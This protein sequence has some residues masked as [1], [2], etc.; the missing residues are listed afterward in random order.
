MSYFYHHKSG[1][2]KRKERIDR[3]QRNL[4][5]ERGQATLPDFN[6]RLKEN[7][8]VSANQSHDSTERRDSQSFPRTSSSTT[9]EPDCNQ[10]ETIVTF[11][12]SDLVQL[13]QENLSVETDV[14]FVATIQK[15]TSTER[16]SEEQPTFQM[17][18]TR[19]LHNYDIGTIETDFLLPQLVDEVIRRGHE[20]MPSAFPRDRLNERFPVSLLFKNLPNGEKVERDW[21]VWSRSKSALFCLPCRLFSTNTVNRSYLCSPGGYSKNLAWKKLYERL[22]PHENNKDHIQCYV[23]WRGLEM[24]IRNESSIDKLLCKQIKVEVKKWQEILTRILDTILFLGERGLAL[25]GKSHLIGKRN[26]G[27]FL[28]ILELIS[29]YDPV[30]HEHLEKVKTSQQQHQR[31]QCHYLSPDI[32]NEFIDLC[33][34]HIVSAILKEREKAKYYS[35]IVD[36]TPD[37]AH[38]EQTTFI[39][40]YVHL[41]PEEKKYTIEERFLEFVDCNKKTGA[42]IADLIRDTLKKHNIPLTECRG[43]GYDNGSNMKGKYKGA[44]SYILQ[45]NSLA[46]YSPCSGHSLNLCG[47]DSAECCSKAITF[48]GVVQKCYTIFSSSPQRWEI[49]KNKIGSS[50]HSSSETRW[51]ARIDAVKPFANYLPGLQSAL[52]DLKTLNLTAETRRDVSGIQKYICKFECI[53]MASIWS[54]IL[55]AINERSIVLQ[56]RNAT[57]DVEVKNLESLLS[58]MQQIRNQW[59]AILRECELVANTADE[60]F[61]DPLRYQKFPLPGRKPLNIFVASLVEPGKS[62]L[63]VSFVE[64]LTEDLSEEVVPEAKELKGEIENLEFNVGMYRR[65]VEEFT[66]TND[67]RMRWPSTAGG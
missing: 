49:L 31:L 25:R 29:H 45:D 26:N 24:S 67:R 47:V 34:R 14:N 60:A 39:L 46:V 20:K 55:N 35:L 38:V 30:L 4:I 53:L 18:L 10:A 51:S 21:L 13:V 15:S 42:A 59:D 1:S 44:Q 11:V 32:Q 61:H 3:E 23:K 22:Q 8:D 36:A 2:L 62:E 37:S 6:F 63:L 58:D 57:I 19:H 7:L 66:S 28:G 65:A 41:N 16:E 12:L 50:L 64:V 56:A 52:E 48:F 43:Q 54:K 40:R 17:H 9:T 5:A 33:A 27:N